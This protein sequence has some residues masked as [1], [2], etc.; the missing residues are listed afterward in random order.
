MIEKIVRDYLTEHLPVPV[1][2]DK[3]VNASGS[4]VVIERVGGSRE[5][6]ARHARMAIQSYGDT[7]REAAELHEEV[8]AVMP[9]MDTVDGG[10]YLE[11]E[12]D[13]T[14]TSTKVYRYQAVFSITYF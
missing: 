6:L 10:V 13:F 3:P 2:T 9:M 7:R 11:G 14:D 5:N 1:Y 12:Y 8:L 4:F